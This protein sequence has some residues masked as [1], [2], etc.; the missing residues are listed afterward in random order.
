MGFPKKVMPK[1]GRR[2]RV[3]C[4]GIAASM[5]LRC[6]GRRNAL[7]TVA[8]PRSCSWFSATSAILAKLTKSNS[9]VQTPYRLPLLEC[10]HDPS[11]PSK[12]KCLSLRIRRR[13]FLVGQ[14]AAKQMVGYF[15]GYIQQEAE[16]RPIRTEA[17]HRSNA[18]FEQ[19]TKC[20]S[21]AVT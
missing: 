2:H 20:T 15:G 12:K 13:Q 21:K 16:D 1:E 7:G 10:T 5:G 8:G 11:C 6:S 18:R 19:Q 17:E 9:N 14:R 4:P 3:I